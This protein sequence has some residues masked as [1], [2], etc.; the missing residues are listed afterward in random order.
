MYTGYNRNK[1]IANKEKNLGKLDKDIN[2]MW[3]SP[4]FD[5]EECVRAGKSSSLKRNEINSLK[6]MNEA[7]KNFNKNINL[8]RYRNKDGSLNIYKTKRPLN[9]SSGECSY[10]SSSKLFHQ[11]IAIG[12]GKNMLYSDY[13]V[14]EGNLNVRFWDSKNPKDTWKDIQKVGKSNASN[15]QV[16]QIFFGQN[17]ENWVNPNDYNLIFHNCQNYSNQ[18]ANNL[19]QYH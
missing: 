4:W 15:E 5:V 8:D 1:V 16:H 14:N 13:G 3:N 10:N 17:S 6:Q 12:N 9:N 7:E 11:G 2:K 19:M 18:T